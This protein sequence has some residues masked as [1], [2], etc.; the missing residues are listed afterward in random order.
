M[1][2]LLVIGLLAWW[3]MYFYQDEFVYRILNARHIQDGSLRM[4]LFSLCESWLATTPLLFHLPAWLTSW[5]YQSLD[6]LAARSAVLAVIVF[7]YLMTIGPKPRLASLLVL[8]SLVGISGSAMLLTRPEYLQLFNIAICLLI[9]WHSQSARHPISKTGRILYSVVLFLSFILALYSHQQAV[10][11]LPLNL[12]ALHGLLRHHRHTLYVF[13][14][15]LIITSASGLYYKQ[16]D[17]SCEN[18]RALSIELASY[19]HRLNELPAIIFSPDI[20]EKSYRY[21]SQFIYKERY[22][23]N[24]LPGTK[25]SSP[26]LALNLL[27]ILTVLLTLLMGIGLCV[28]ATYQLASQRL[29]KRASALPAHH[30]L[31][32]LIAGPAIAL[33]LVNTG[34]H[35]YRCIFIHTLITAALSLYFVNREGPPSRGCMLLLLMLIPAFVGSTWFNYQSI[36][37]ALA[38]GY[39]GSG[40]AMSSMM[41]KRHVMTNSCK[42]DIA[43]G[44]LLVDAV[45]YEQLKHV[46][47]LYPIEYLM[48]QN[49][50]TGVPIETI[51]EGM[52]MQGWVG[53][54]PGDNDQGRFC[55]G[56]FTAPSELDR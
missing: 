11:F 16:S 26:L 8:G 56:K 4:G 12:Y 23:V 20:L 48:F 55:C 36:R 54:C 37:P 40:A 43:H 9:H 42:L 38:Q 49:R 25:L 14:A 6:P 22:P 44:H 46:P 35:F 19:Q 30:L 7:F 51:V 10:L 24:L 27:I 52:D 15:A 28:R 3:P 53:V 50:K 1:I 31:S 18:N 32:L 17:L 13:S 47:R 41:Q 29:F 5:W 34:Q 2:L 33:L 39:V 21:T 45:T